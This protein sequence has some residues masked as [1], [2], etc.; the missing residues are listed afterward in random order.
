[1]K[2]FT[3]LIL[4]L[5]L[6]VSYTAV[7]MTGCGGGGGDITDE[8]DITVG[9]LTD[10]YAAQLVRDGAGVILGVIEITEGEDGIVFVDVAERE[11]VESQDQPNGFYIADKNL[12]GTYQLSADA[13]ATFL[14]G[15][16]SIAKPMEADEFVA[17]V[18]KDLDEYGGSDPDYKNYKLYDIYVIDDQILLLLARY[19]P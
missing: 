12:E 13:R 7:F 18:G 3:V 10:E 1:M 17:A 15:G 9:Y 16:S 4:I 5:T 14:A 6:A 11:Y 2:R 8:P 19:L